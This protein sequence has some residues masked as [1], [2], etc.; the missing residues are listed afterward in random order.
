MADISSL[1]IGAGVA[2]QGGTLRYCPGNAA[3]ICYSVG[4]PTTSASSDSGNIYFQISAPTTYQWVALGTGT[5]MSGSNIFIMYQDGKGNVT[6]SPRIGGNHVM[7]TLDTS[8]NAAQLT[9]LAGSGVSADGSTMTANVACA[10]CESWSGGGELDLKDAQS[11]WIGAWRKGS[12]IDTTSRSASLVQHDDTV[13][14]EFDLT[15]A[16]VTADSNPFVAAAATGS[17]GGNDTDG[18]GSDS[19]GSGDGSSGSSDGSGVTV[20]SNDDNDTILVA[21]GV[22]M[23]IVFVI[24]YPLGALLIPLLGRWYAHAGFQA[25]VWLLMWAGFGLG[26]KYAKDLNIVSPNRASYPYRSL[27]ISKLTK[28]VL[29][30]HSCSTRLTPFSE[31]WSCASW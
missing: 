15:K 8:A 28:P 7:P 22:I 9:V 30:H 13:I 16:V 21:H 29:C 25:V 27:E 17:G 14:F 4:V 24:L 26:V 19:G 10:N 2:A 31:P 12:A 3:G 23:S 5:G 20:V 18:S 11:G 1:H 6:L